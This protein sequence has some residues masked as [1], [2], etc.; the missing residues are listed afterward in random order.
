MTDFQSR[1]TMCFFQ[2][3]LVPS[4]Q[5]GECLFNCLLG[6]LL[7]RSRGGRTPASSSGLRYLARGGMCR[8]AATVP[9]SARARGLDQDSSPRR[10]KRGA[11]S[12]EERAPFGGWRRS[13]SLWGLA[14]AVGLVRWPVCLAGEVEKIR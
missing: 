8:V 5:E 3:W 1:R 13:S 11:V 10:R 12:A 2:V 7:T 14:A 6:C 9:K 4:N